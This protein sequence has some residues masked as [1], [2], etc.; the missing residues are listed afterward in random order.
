MIFDAPRASKQPGVR[1][2]EQIQQALTTLM[3]TTTMAPYPVASVQRHIPPTSLKKRLFNKFVSE[4]RKQADKWNPMTIP[5]AKY[6]PTPAACVNG[7]R[8]CSRP[9]IG[10]TNTFDR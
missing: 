2:A 10:I 8:L 1:L 7:I 9:R 5:Q 4:G 3:A 6:S